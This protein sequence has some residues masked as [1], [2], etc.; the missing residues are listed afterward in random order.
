MVKILFGAGLFILWTELPGGFFFPLPPMRITNQTNSL[1]QTRMVSVVLC[2]NVEDMSFLVM[3]CTLGWMYLERTDIGKGGQ[4]L[5]VWG[6][7]KKETYSSCTK[8]IFRRVGEI[9]KSD[10][11]LRH[12]RPSVRMEQLISHWTDFHEIWYLRI[13]RKSVEKI[14]VSLKSD[15]N[16]RYFTWRPIYIFNHISLISSQNEKCFRQT[17]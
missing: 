13:N 3:V 17:L 14:Q 1:H 2:G 11:Q 9:A 15:E 10:Y 5:C 12:I 4:G 6:C 7:V 8:L 16:N